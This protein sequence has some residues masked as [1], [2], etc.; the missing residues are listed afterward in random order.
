[1]A[2]MCLFL[3]V[4]NVNVAEACAARVTESFSVFVPQLLQGVVRGVG[5]IYA[6]EELCPSLLILLAVLICSPLLCFHALLGSGA[7][8]LAGEWTGS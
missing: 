3:K 1:M 5:Q 4:L 7:G 6:C 8:L 2:Q